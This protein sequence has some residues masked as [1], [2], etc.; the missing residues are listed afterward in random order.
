MAVEKFDDYSYVVNTDQH[1]VRDQRFL[2]I[3]AKCNKVKLKVYLKTDHLFFFFKESIVYS[4]ATLR[5]KY[6]FLTMIT[7]M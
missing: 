3:K 2:F 1:D 5:K 7:A 6:Y 4:L